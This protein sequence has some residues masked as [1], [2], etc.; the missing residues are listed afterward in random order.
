[1]GSN[2]SLESDNP[3]QFEFFLK[4]IK[5]QT[6]EIGVITFKLEKKKTFSSNH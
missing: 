5:L 2:I 1:M 3:N 4:K 6:K